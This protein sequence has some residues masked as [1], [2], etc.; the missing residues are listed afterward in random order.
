MAIVI[1]KM[2]NY[3]VGEGGRRVILLLDGILWKFFK[4]ELAY[5]NFN[6]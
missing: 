1:L 6:M 2:R 4:G 5:E 3:I